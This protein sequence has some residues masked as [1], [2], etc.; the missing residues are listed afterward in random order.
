MVNV[1]FVYDFDLTLSEE[2]QQIPIFKV[3]AD[4]LKQVHGI[5]DFNDYWKLMDEDECNLDIGYMQQFLKDTPAIFWGLTNKRMEKEFG[6]QIQ[7]SPGIPEWFEK[8]NEHVRSLGLEPQHHVISSG[9]HHLVKGSAVAPHLSSIHAGEFLDDGTNMIKIKKSVHPFLKVAC[10]KEICKGTD[11]YKDLAMNQY[12]IN[13]EFVFVFGDGQSDRN[14]FRYV[15][16]A[17]GRALAVFEKSNEKAFEVTKE[18]LAGDVNLIVPRDYRS[19]STLMKVVQ[20]SLEEMAALARGECD[21]DYSL[22]HCYKLKQLRSPEIAKI[23]EKHLS[24][25]DICQNRL[26]SKFYSE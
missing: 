16:E 8:I 17:G 14:M 21:M 13:H 12:N 7:L 26:E 11:L 10:L 6:P 19:D 24:D 4:R 5:T 3:F 22:V 25:C 18:K 23:V 2:F 1:G 9:I 15:K 20:E